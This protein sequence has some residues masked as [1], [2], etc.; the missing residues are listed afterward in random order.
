M[1]EGRQ[2]LGILNHL[3]W[4]ILWYCICCCSS[5]AFR[6]HAFLLASCSWIWEYMDK[7]IFTW[8]TGRHRYKEQI[9]KSKCFISLWQSCQVLLQ[10]RTTRSPMS[11]RQRSAL[12]LHPF[13]PHTCCRSSWTRTQAFLWVPQSV[14]WIR[15][16]RTQMDGEKSG[17]RQRALKEEP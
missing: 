17:C 16:L 2:T 12:N 7:W 3:Q 14:C 6:S 10:D 4:L 15:A 13:F 5:C 1:C 9:F 11:V 8:R